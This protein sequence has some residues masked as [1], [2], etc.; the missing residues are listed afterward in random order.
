MSRV[1]P[2]AKRYDQAL[3]RMM[4]KTVS[5]SWD[6]F[7]LQ[8]ELFLVF[9][10]A[11]PGMVYGCLK[12]ACTEKH[13]LDVHG[14]LLSSPSSYHIVECY[15]L[16]EVW[17]RWLNRCILPSKPWVLS[18]HI[19]FYFL[20]PTALLATKIDHHGSIGLPRQLPIGLLR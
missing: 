14:Q 3:W 13:N 9:W 5:R 8:A 2:H 1:V 17:F 20:D 18:W 6:G 10:K 7:S 16:I 4:G 19:A 12:R 11:I 15:V